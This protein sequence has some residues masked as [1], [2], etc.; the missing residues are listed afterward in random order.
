MEKHLL[1]TVL[2]FFMENT[3][4]LF[5][6]LKTFFASDVCLIFK[7]PFLYYSGRRCCFRSESCPTLLDPV[8]CSP[9]VHVSQ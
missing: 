6:N 7:S 3:F 2:A 9:P 5:N 4:S 8:D 1:V